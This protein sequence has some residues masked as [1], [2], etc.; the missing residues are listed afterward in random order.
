M[1]LLLVF[2]TVLQW[3]QEAIAVLVGVDLGSQYFKAAIVSPG[4]PF[5]VVHNTHSK[6]K[7]PTVV[8]F[9]EKVRTF[10]DDA[11]ASAGRSLP[12]TPMFFPFELGRNLTGVSAD[13][14]HWLPRRFFPYN[15]GVN[16]SGSLRFQFSEDKDSD[17]YT[18]E[19][20]TAH[21]LGFVK[22]LAEEAADGNPVTETVITVP[23]EATMVQRRAILA[24]AEIA[25]LP[26]AH[27]IHETSA[28]ALQRGPDLQLGTKGLDANGTNSTP[29]DNKTTSTVLYYN[30]GARHV[31]VCIVAYRGAT[32]MSKPTVAMDVLGCA[33]TRAAGGHLVDMVVADEMRTAFGKKNPKL[34]E[35]LSSSVRSLKKLEKEAMSLKHVLSANKEAQFRVE[36]LYEDTDFSHV[37]SRE[38]LESWAESIFARANQPI[39]AALSAAN[40]SLQDIDTVEMVGGG[41]RIPKVQTLLSEY[42]Q[43]HRPKD[44]PILNLSQHLNGEEAM[45]TGAAFFGANSSTSFRTKKIFFTDVTPHSYSLLLSPLNA[46]QLNASQE[47]WERGVELFPAYSKLRARKTVKL[48]QDFDIAMV[49][50]ENGNHVARWE[51]TGIHQAAS[52]THAA[53][54]TPLVSLKLELDSSGIVQVTSA[55]AIFDEPVL[56]AKTSD[57]NAS[58]PSNTTEQDANPSE[59]STGAEGTDGAE[60]APTSE[61][62]ASESSSANASDANAKTKTKIKKRKVQLTLVEHFEG[63]LPRPLSAEEKAWAGDRL[64]TM[65]EADAEVHRSVAAKNNLEAYIYESREKVTGDELYLQVS[66]E[67]EREEVGSKLTEAE[68]WLYE[69]EAMNGNASVFEA[70]IA[71][72]SEKVSP[73][74]IRAFE[75]EQRPLLPELV[76][77]VS[78]WVNQTLTYVKSNMTWVAAKEIEGVQN[79]TSY[80]EEWYANVTTLQAQTPL[81]EM[82]VYTTRDVQVRLERMRSEAHRLSRIQKI[83]PMPYSD[84]SRYGR[85]DG[86][87]GSGY[88][89]AR[90][91]DFYRYMYENQ[92]NGSN[93]SEFMRNFGAGGNYSNFDW[94]NSDYMRS[95]YE[96][97]AKNFSDQEKAQ[98]TQNETGTGQDKAD[99]DNAEL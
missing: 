96:H 4:K 31:E 80:F 25:R 73:I 16:S 61:A 3:H 7:T 45:A 5:D 72:L 78:E 24:A 6:R 32:H 19:E 23:S 51:L 40:V 74:K 92:S 56:V 66:T 22:L 28:A 53:L 9:H 2:F 79:L 67:E 12:K 36:A 42:L 26:R 13:D 46:S 89:D 91:R 20:A 88:D 86:Y 75:L 58:S 57:T 34:A 11:M 54:D 29:S 30:M 1:R 8:S 37:V 90:M 59:S 65:N 85:Y 83:D 52:V 47:D 97:M 10:G 17:G 60:E 87:G 49:L 69:D 39:P 84:Y 93:Y 44:A 41:W 98:G 18:V 76:E 27:L 21:V 35:G 95:F 71:A 68:D 48:H 50:L 38:V 94:N 77:K 15:L 62:N 99:A 33:S 64:R 82:P 70:K 14:L 43:R 55:Q 81:T 63:I